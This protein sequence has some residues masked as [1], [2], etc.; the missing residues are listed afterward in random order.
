MIDEI[1]VSFIETV[2]K[3]ED[4]LRKET[5]D[6]NFSILVEAEGARV[7][8]VALAGEH[9]IIPAA[10]IFNKAGENWTLSL[11]EASNYGY[12]TGQIDKANK[13]VERILKEARR[14]GVE[15]FGYSRV[16]TRV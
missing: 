8:Y 4:R 1:K 7:L 15:V 9:S 14:L 5:G 3:L 12:F 16:W 10:K 6:P 13:I 11:F 2:K